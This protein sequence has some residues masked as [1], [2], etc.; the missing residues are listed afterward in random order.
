M[1]SNIQNN[2][3]LPSVGQNFILYAN[4]SNSLA[5]LPTEIFI[6]IL[7]FTDLLSLYT[8]KC[9]THSFKELIVNS[10]QSQLISH[11]FKGPFQIP[12]LLHGNLNTVKFVNTKAL[13]THT[14]FMKSIG[15]NKQEKVLLTYLKDPQVN[16]LA[17]R[18][19][20][21]KVASAYGHLKVMKFLIERGVDPSFDNNYALINSSKNGQKNIVKFLLEHPNVNLAN[22]LNEA[23]QYAC[24]NH[25][26][27]IIKTLIKDSR[28]DP[29]SNEN[30]AITKASECGYVKI[31]EL[32][33]KH[34][35]VNPADSDNASIRLASVCGHLQVVKLLLNDSRVD[36]TAK[37]NEAIK[38]AYERGHTDVVEILN[39]RV[40]TLSSRVNFIW[41]QSISYLLENYK[42]LKMKISHLIRKIV[43]YSIRYHD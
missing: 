2:I 13:I 16:V 1:V 6:S 21:I 4:S 8:L 26:P 14:I 38:R 15:K 18:N 25:Q 34:P 28:V 12:V 29:S 33:L 40:N 35:N 20:A 23:L 3:V 30:Q 7:G 31:V 36:P 43:S 19:I 17:D 27:R 9:S 22:G 32:L 11:L 42:F 37:N 24:E 41:K 5:C 10:I 39:V